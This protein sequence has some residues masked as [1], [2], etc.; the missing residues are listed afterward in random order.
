MKEVCRKYKE[1]M[2]ENE[3]NMVE[4]RRNHERIK[5]YICSPVHEQWDMEKLQA[6]AVGLGKILGFSAG[7][8]GGS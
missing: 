2:K 7:V 5:E 6:L 3:E 1:I 8:G 4:R